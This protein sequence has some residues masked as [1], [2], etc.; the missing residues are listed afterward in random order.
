MRR[1]ASD[2]TITEGTPEEFA[3]YDRALRGCAVL[4][5][6]AVPTPTAPPW[7][8]PPQWWQ[9]AP[10]FPFAPTVICGGGIPPGETWSGE[11]SF[12]GVAPLTVGA[13]VLS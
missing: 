12:R 8:E 13:G 2:G 10:Y 1:I 4:L 3:V 5:P 11:V 9:P 6:I 7:W